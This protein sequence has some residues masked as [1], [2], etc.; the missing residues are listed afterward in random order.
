VTRN[1]VIE[2]LYRQLNR[3]IRRSR[4]L[5]NELHPASTNPP[6]PVSSTNW[7]KKDCWTGWVDARDAAAI[8][9]R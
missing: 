9:S 7:P 5:S 3:L 6:F 1:D 4:E 2:D 8:L